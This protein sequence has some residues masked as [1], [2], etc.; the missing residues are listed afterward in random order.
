M[1]FDVTSPRFKRFNDFLSIRRDD[2]DDD[3]GLSLLSIIDF[4]IFK[5]FKSFSS[6]SS[7]LVERGRFDVIFPFPSKRDRD[8]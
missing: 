6:S 8:A 5:L 2:D 1:S 7:I 4:S 3:V